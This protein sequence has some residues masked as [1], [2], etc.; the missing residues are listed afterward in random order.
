MCALSILSLVLVNDKYKLRLILFCLA[1]VARRH[2]ICKDF[3]PSS[4]NFSHSFFEMGFSEAIVDLMAWV[5]WF[6][7]DSKY[8]MDKGWRQADIIKGK[9][10]NFFICRKT[11]RKS[12][13]LFV[14]LSDFVSIVYATFSIPFQLQ[15]IS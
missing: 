4:K 10:Y 9:G 8:L 3:L 7:F 11:T 1:V 5:V 14:F 6:L 12:N 2:E 15:A 13:N